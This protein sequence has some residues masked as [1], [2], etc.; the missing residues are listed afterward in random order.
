MRNLEEALQFLVDYIRV[1][2]NSPHTSREE[3][4][5]LVADLLTFLRG[6]DS[7]EGIR[8]KLLTVGRARAIFLGC[9]P[10]DECPP[11]RQAFVWDIAYWPLGEKEMQDRNK[12]LGL[13]DR[14]FRNHY[15]AARLAIAGIFNYDLENEKEIKYGDT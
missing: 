3:R 2:P 5:G 7:K 1:G 14:H 12:L 11:I 15:T 4:R 13:C 9:T 8:L 6:P 10:D